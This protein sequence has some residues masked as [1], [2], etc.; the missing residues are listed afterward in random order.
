MSKSLQEAARDVLE[1]FDAYNASK[2]TPGSTAELYEFL[3]AALAAEAEPP[4]AEASQRPEPNALGAIVG[5]FA[6][7]AE[8]EQQGARAASQRPSYEELVVMLNRALGTLGYL[9]APNSSVAGIASE[10]EQDARALLARCGKG[11]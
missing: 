6:N 10:F 2:A 5:A 8:L 9:P 1:Q 11:G 7:A 4:I 3:R